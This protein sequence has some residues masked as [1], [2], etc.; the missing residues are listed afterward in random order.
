MKKAVNWNTL[1]LTIGISIGSFIGKSLFTEMKQIHDDVLIINAKMPN[2]IDRKE[3]DVAMMEIKAK[4]AALEI[5][6]LEL[7][8]KIK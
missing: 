7:E 5:K 2:F 4:Q 1:L 3:F 6:M 8:A